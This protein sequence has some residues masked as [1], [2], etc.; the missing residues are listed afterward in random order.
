MSLIKKE[1]RELNP[2]VLLTFMVILAAILSYVVPAGKFKR[3]AD[4]ASGRVLVV[5]DSYQ[6]IEQTPVKIQDVFLAFPNGMVAAGILIFGMFVAGGAFRILEDMG[7]INAFINFLVNRVKGK[8]ILLIPV[9]MAA[10]SVGGIAG[11]NSPVIIFMPLGLV[12]TRS[13]GFDA[14]VGM[15]MVYFGTYAAFDT[16]PVLP[17][18]VGIAHQI[19]QIPIFSG[20]GP[21]GLICLIT[22]LST[23]AYVCWYALRVKKNP[24]KSLVKDINAKFDFDIKIEASRVMTKRDWV[25]L[26][27]TTASI[28]SL[29]VGSVKYHW[30]FMEISALFVFMAIVTGLV[31]GMSVNATA[32]SFVKGMAGITNGAM[33]IGFAY[34]VQYILNKGN[35]IDTIIYYLSLGLVGLS[36]SLAAISMFF[37]NC[38]SAF[39]ITSGSGQAAAVMPIMYPIG[40]LL[41]VTRQVSA[42][43]FLFADGFMNGLS[44]TS[45]ML[46]AA[47][48]IAKIP[49][50]RWIRFH[51][52]L[53]V[54]W[55][56][57]AMVSLIL[58]VQLNW[59]P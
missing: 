40:D 55:V 26:G 17:T 56:V 54:I 15:A 8:E 44:P 18:S 12:I 59:G 58:G 24:A 23:I 19:G 5:K 6:R 57:I 14:M 22:V 10:F 2:F 42:Q 32:E 25:V 11:I 38:F 4:P 21:R 28:L 7:T 9:V 47:L 50:G 13:L 3:E 53:L 31:G 41:G 27:I 48:A 43:A 33:I 46:M 16:S 45:G 51:I 39:L 1:P 36:P 35:I 49:F 52:P 30:E 34:A 20:A 29:V 37:V